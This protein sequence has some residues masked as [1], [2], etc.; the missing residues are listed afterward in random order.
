MLDFKHLKI[1]LWHKDEH[2]SCVVCNGS[3]GYFQDIFPVVLL[4]SGKGLSKFSFFC[5]GYFCQTK[6][7][8]MAA[9]RR[10]PKDEISWI[11][12]NGSYF[13]KR[14]ETPTSCAIDKI[15]F[16]KNP[17]IIERIPGIL[18]QEYLENFLAGMSSAR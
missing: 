8:G 12:V 5:L 9:N 3:N 16:L 18:K 11:V 1:C 10:I 6:I 14:R 4:D 2:F 17:F 13:F 15:R 7:K